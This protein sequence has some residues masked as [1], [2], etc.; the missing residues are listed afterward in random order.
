MNGVTINGAQFSSTDVGNAV[1]PA[2]TIFTVISNTSATDTS[3]AFSN[4]PEGGTITIGINTFQAD[5]GGGDG[6]DLTLTAI[7]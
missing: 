1:L 7:P 5:Y 4:L 3:G 6:N 2:G